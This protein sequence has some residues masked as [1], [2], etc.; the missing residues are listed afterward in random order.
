M[1]KKLGLILLLLVTAIS[2]FAL[3][4]CDGSSSKKKDKDDDDDE[5]HSHKYGTWIEEIPATC[6]E[7]GVLGHYHCKSCGKDFDS[8][9]N[10]LASL[11]IEK[12]GIHN[13]VDEVCTNCGKEIVY[14]EGLEYE[15]VN[16]EYYK[17]TGIGTCS[18]TELYI[19]KIYNDLPVKEI[20]YQAF[21]Y[22]DSLTS[23]TI[24]DSV[25]SIGTYAFNRCRSLTNIVI[26]NSITSIGY[27]AFDDCTSLVSILIPESVTSIGI[28]AFHDCY[29]LVE[30]I[31]KS[32][33]DITKA[34]YG[35]SALE[36]HTDATKIVNKDEYL[37]YTYDETN[38]LLGYV[39]E[40]TDLILPESYNGE[41]YE[42]YKHAFFVRHDITSITIPDS[43][44]SIGERAF[45]SCEKL[46]SVMIGNGVASIGE[47]AFYNCKSLASVTIG[48]RVEII[49]DDAFEDCYKLVEVINK[50]SLNIVTDSLDYG[51]VA[52]YAKEVHNGK[53]KIVNKN[54]FT[55]YKYK[56]TN[57]LLG[58]IGDTTDLILPESYN[59]ENYEIYERAFYKREDIT[60]VTIPNGVTSI[61]EW[62]FE[63]CNSLA[64]AKISNSVTSIGEGAFYQCESIASITLGNKIESIGG[65]AFAECFGLTSIIIPNSVASIGYMAFDCCGGL[66]SIT[67][68]DTSTWYRTTN[69]S[70][71]QNKTDGTQTDVSVPTNNDDYFQSTYRD[72]YW[73]KK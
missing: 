48:N 65:Y 62:A 73:Y 72:Y 46:T 32:S 50:S 15:L 36:V 64:S 63:Y 57:F 8:N 3:S 29:K 37:F 20:G 41:K 49:C 17:V 28:D 67:F 11:V 14:S 6:A 13:F 26:P 44:S 24:P 12:T 5:S 33:L 7:D 43:V 39:G 1:K 18:D 4:A 21:Y 35:L 47:G 53:T 40:D 51:K 42:I 54:G 27:G 66:E 10:E 16:N 2:I 68:A 52:Y 59:G 58:Y 45:T 56:G 34:S 71:W 70:D 69:E 30:V 9:K 55:F 25:T 61:G 19:P 22:C 60:N 23:V 31:N 38:F